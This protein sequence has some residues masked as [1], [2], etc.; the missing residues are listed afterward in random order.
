LYGSLRLKFS[1][2][3]RGDE[4]ILNHTTQLSAGE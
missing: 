2:T 4:S 3:N 1:V